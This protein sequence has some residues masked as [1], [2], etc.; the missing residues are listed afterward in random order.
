MKGLI[1]LSLIVL[2]ILLIVVMDWIFGDDA[3]RRKF[4]N[5]AVLLIIVGLI[6]H[7]IDINGGFGCGSGL[8]QEKHYK[9]LSVTP[10]GGDRTAV[11][12][13]DADG[14]VAPIQFYA[15][16]KVDTNKLYTV[17][18]DRLKNYTLTPVN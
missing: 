13:R 5:C 15:P 14:K 11:I 18:G 16:L 8:C 3:L 6:H 1:M 9:V 10:L 2:G 4:A 12:L 17:A 7:A